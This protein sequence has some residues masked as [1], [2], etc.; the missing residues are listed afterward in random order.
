ML[1]NDETMKCMFSGGTVYITEVPFA[2]DGSWSPWV[3]SGCSVSC[4]GGTLK[5]TRTCTN[6]APANNGLACQGDDIDLSDCN[7]ND[8]PGNT[9]LYNKTH[10]T[11]MECTIAAMALL[12]ELN[13]LTYMP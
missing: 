9:S 5:R 1:L 13:C 4:G 11:Y 8:C 2:V 3:D 6:P 10:T 12:L 7:P